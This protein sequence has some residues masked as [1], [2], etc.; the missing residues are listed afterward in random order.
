VVARYLSGGST[1]EDPVTEPQPSPA[2]PNNSGDSR[3]WRRYIKYVVGILATFGILGAVG[4]RAVDKVFSTAEE[5]LNPEKTVFV[6]VREDPHGGSDG[7]TLASRS[8][9]GLDAALKDITDC[10]NL[11]DA[12]KRAGAIDVGAVWEALLLEGGTSRDLS[13]VDM[14]AKILKREPPLAGAQIHCESAGGQEAIGVL[15]L[16]DEAQPVAREIGPPLDEVLG[17]GWGLNYGGPYFGR[18]NTV[19]LEKGETQPFLLIGV[20]NSDYVE[21]VVEADV[22]IDGETQT[23]TI[24]NEGEPFRVTGWEDVVYGRYYEWQWYEQPQ[25]MW[26]DDHPPQP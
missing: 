25:R 4:N 23:I 22:L 21:W 10:G 1:Q 19:R 24:D 2:E 9:E 15:F 20:S 11:F 3:H 8:P 16:L 18:G 5:K 7:F 26:I 17:S 14:R 6:G 13:I 12:A